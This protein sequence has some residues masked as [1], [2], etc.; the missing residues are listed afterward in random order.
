MTGTHYGASDAPGGASAEFGAGVGQLLR[1]LAFAACKHED[2][3]RK[4]RKSVPYI[5]HPIRVTKLLW[6]VGGIRTGSILIAALLHDT[7]EDTDTTADEIEQRFGRE[8]LA[9]V[10]EVSDDKTLPK[11]LR[12]QLQVEHAPDQSYGSKLI[13]LADK[14][15]N[16]GD[17]CREPP[18]GWS[19]ERIVEYIDW[20]ERVVLGL[21]GVNTNLERVFDDAVWAARSRLAHADGLGVDD[22]LS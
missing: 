8:V 2:Q 9:L 4:G 6:E 12:K 19:R 13:K 17:L 11:A 21:R 16:L 7:L 18:V 20:S 3:R 14:I 22:A 1:A 10:Q 15:D 5:N